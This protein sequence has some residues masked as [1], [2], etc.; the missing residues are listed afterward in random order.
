METL[1]GLDIS[2]NQFLKLPTRQQ[3]VILY[4]NL[5]Q[6]RISVQGYKFHQKVQYAWL[7]ALTIAVGLGKF[8]GVI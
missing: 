1:N 2:E 5:R 4:K 3:N 7:S 6:I 8:M